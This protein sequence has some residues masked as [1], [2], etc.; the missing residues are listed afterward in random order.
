MKI[1]MAD[2]NAL[3]R[4]VLQ[5]ALAHL[6]CEIVVCKDGSEAWSHLERPQGPTIAI[7]DWMMPGFNGPEVCRRVRKSPASS[8]VYIVLLTSLDG[9]GNLVEGLEAGADDYIKNPFNIEELKARLHVGTRVLHLQE[10]LRKRVEDLEEALTNVK[11]L[12]RLLPICSYC[13]KIRDD[14]NYWQQVD[15]Y[16]VQH[17]E[18]RFS[19][20]FCPD[21]YEKH[22]KVQLASLIEETSR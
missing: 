16:I 4:R 20:G 9:T 7:L 5:M 6:G 22:V 11:R 10:N 1:L 2:D 17:S 19:H 15:Q 18:T 12:Q 13:K 8:F 21:C 14:K 3:E